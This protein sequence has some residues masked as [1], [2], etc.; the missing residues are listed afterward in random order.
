MFP[1]VGPNDAVDDEVCRGV[2]HHQDVGDVAE[3]DCPD[4]EASQQGLL[5]VKTVLH[6]VQSPDL[7]DIEEQPGGLA[8]EEGQHDEDENN[9]Q[10]GLLLL[11]PLPELADLPVDCDVDYGEDTEG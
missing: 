5:D 6:L 10:I 8:E 4:G 7:V 11:L 3:E 2:D 1:H 9:T